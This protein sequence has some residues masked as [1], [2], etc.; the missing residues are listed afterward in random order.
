MSDLDLDLPAGAKYVRNFLSP[1]EEARLTAL[2]DQRAWSTELKRRVQHF[3][4]RYDYRART[5][6]PNA[7]LGPLPSWLSVLGARLVGQ[8]HFTEVPDQVIVNEYEPAQGIS[9]HV[10]CIPCFEDTIASLSLLSPCEML[11]R[12]Q[13]SGERKSA[14]LEPCSVLVLKGAARYDWTHEIPARKFDI[15]DGTKIARRRRVS[16]TFRKVIEN[17]PTG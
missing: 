16:L 11:F 7:F 4:Y 6:L 3:G 5:V 17:R 13:Q 12:N 10:D 8:G 15:V 1:A 14:I 9:A 2:L